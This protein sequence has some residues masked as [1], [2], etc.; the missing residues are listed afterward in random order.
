MAHPEGYTSRRQLSRMD[1]RRYFAVGFSSRRPWPCLPWSPVTSSDVLPA[2]PASP[3]LPSRVRPTR[4]PPPGATFRREALPAADD[5]PDGLGF[6]GRKF[7]THRAHLSEPR[8]VL[9]PAPLGFRDR[10]RHHLSY[11]LLERGRC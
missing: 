8:A 4:G 5:G 6:G 2:G 9:D 10:G 11:G 3:H 7:D 1:D